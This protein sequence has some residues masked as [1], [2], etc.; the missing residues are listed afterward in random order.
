VLRHVAAAIP[1]GN[2]W[3]PV[4]AR[5]LGE[6]EDRVRAFGGDPDDALPSPTGHPA[7]ALPGEGGVFPGV[8]VSGRIGRLFYD[9]LGDFEGFELRNCDG[10][11]RIPA[12]ERGI[13]RVVL[14]ACERNLVLTIHRKPNDPQ[15]QRFT[16]GCGPCRCCDHPPEPTRQRVGEPPAAPAPRPEPRRRPRTPPADAGRAPVDPAHGD[17]GAE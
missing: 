11:I 3:E 13:E 17:H 15:A 8:C 14:T 1:A 4:F 12:C 9:C 2:R 7:G 10:T 16:L 6:L 5:Y